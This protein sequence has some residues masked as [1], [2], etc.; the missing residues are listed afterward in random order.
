MGLP[1]PKKMAGR[2]SAM[3]NASPFYVASR[4]RREQL[5]ATPADCRLSVTPAAAPGLEGSTAMA[6]YVTLVRLRPSRSPSWQALDLSN[7]GALVSDR[8]ALFGKRHAERSK[9]VSM[10]QDHG[11]HHHDGDHHGD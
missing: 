2:I 11:D 6:L 4:S 1:C 7:P 9:R 10:S 3:R 5:V 8:L